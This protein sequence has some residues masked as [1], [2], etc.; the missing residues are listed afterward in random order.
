MC[1]TY[2]HSAAA[3][4]MCIFR[5]TPPKLMHWMLTSNNKQS[6]YQWSWINLDCK[7]TSR[8]MNITQ[9]QMEENKNIRENIDIQRN[10]TAAF[11]SHAKNVHNFQRGLK[12]ETP[13]VWQINAY[14]IR[15]LADGDQN[16]SRLKNEKEKRKG[17]K[18]GG[19]LRKDRTSS[20][21]SWLC[22]VINFQPLSLSQAL[23]VE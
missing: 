17:E 20:F 8:R 23:H 12:A 7:V 1:L 6:T 16:N 22:P 18:R 2:N 11:A 5:K 15:R 3:L 14:C 19:G 21:S 13:P 9:C 10:Y 4:C